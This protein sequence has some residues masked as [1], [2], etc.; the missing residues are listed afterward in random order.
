MSVLKSIN[1]VNEQVFAEFQVIS[2]SKVKQVILESS[3]AQ[4]QWAQ[5]NI[6]SRI[7]IIYEVKKMILEKKRVLSHKQY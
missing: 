1:P 7:K 4:E 2:L 3:K 6:K 5:L